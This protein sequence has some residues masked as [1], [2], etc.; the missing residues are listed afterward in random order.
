M[1]SSILLRSVIALCLCGL[2][3]SQAWAE[4]IINLVL[5]DTGAA[6][7]EAA[8]AFRAGIGQRGLVKTWSLADLSASQMQNMTR[9]SNL[10]APVGVKAARFVAENHGGQAPVLNLMIP[11]SASEKLQWPAGL[12]RK[13]VSAVFIDQPPSRSLALVAAAF[14][15]AHRV[16]LVISPENAAVAKALAQEA[17]RRKLHLNLETVESAEDVSAALR[18]VL[19]DSDVLLLV[20]D[21]IAIN[22]G[23]AQNVLL[24]TYR[25]RVPVVGFS[26]GLSNA[27][28]VASVY[29][30]PAQIGLQGAQFALRMDDA[31]ELPLAQHATESSLAFNLY[32]ARSLGVEIQSES[33]IRRKMKVGND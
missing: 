16:G 10:L 30:S 2:S 6:Y 24:T 21:A 11:R 3:I 4:R 12:E 27:G 5:S 20:P 31:G 7:Q 23:N 22:S 14:P 32:V 25:Y 8:S 33:E 15:Y 28:A 13:K 29:S 19:A 18:R 9:S 1:V 17:S 26:E